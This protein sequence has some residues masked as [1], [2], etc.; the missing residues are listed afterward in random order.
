MK[1]SASGRPSAFGGRAELPMSADS[2]TVIRG[3]RIICPGSGLDLQT[4]ILV[5]DGAIAAVSTNRATEPLHV[6]DATGKVVCPG[7]ID[8]HVHLREP[9]AEQKETIRT[10]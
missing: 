2:A 5:R 4:D 3:G 9:G 10:G 7:L 8:V 6:I 1:A